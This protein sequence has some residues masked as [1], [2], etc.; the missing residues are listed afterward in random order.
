MLKDDRILLNDISVSSFKIKEME[1]DRVNEFNKLLDDFGFGYKWVNAWELEELLKKFIK[2]QE[3]LWISDYALSTFQIDFVDYALKELNEDIHSTIWKVDDRYF[4]FKN[5]TVATIN[6]DFS[7]NYQ[8]E[9]PKAF[10]YFDD[11]E[12]EWS[13]EDEEDIDITILDVFDNEPQT[14]EV[15]A[16]YHNYKNCDNDLVEHS[17]DSLNAYVKWH[18]NLIVWDNKRVVLDNDKATEFVQEHLNKDNQLSIETK[19]LIAKSI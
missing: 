3:Y 6:I 10:D 11:C 8:A 14:F 18:H 1:V 17:I 19:E 13:A 2:T 5:E 15:D 12:E 9:S 4:I 7:I 16:W